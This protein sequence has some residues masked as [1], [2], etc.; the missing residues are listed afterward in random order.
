MQ[1]FWDILDEYWGHT[2]IFEPDAYPDFDDTGSSVGGSLEDIPPI[3]AAAG[4]SDAALEPPPQTLPMESQDLAEL[5]QTLP[6]ESQDP[7]EPPQTLPMEYQTL[8]MESQDVAD[9]WLDSEGITPT[10][11]EESPMP[12]KDAAAPAPVGP[13]TSLELP[14]STPRDEEQWKAANA[15]IASHSTGDPASSSAGH[16]ASAASVSVACAVCG[17][18]GEHECLDADPGPSKE[19][20]EEECGKIKKDLLEKIRNLKWEIQTKHV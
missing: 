17:K 8:A 11:L 12:L 15:A 20:V 7:A 5:P 4:A 3:E 16:S 10:V 9:T 13:T 14:D 1:P 2:A 6:M 19:E 18:E